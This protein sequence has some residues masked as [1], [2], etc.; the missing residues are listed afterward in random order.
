MHAAPLHNQPAAAHESES[1]PVGKLP[2]LTKVGL[3]MVETPPE[4]VA[5]TIEEVAIPKRSKRKI[6][7]EAVSVA[8]AEPLLQVETR[9]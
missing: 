9:E 6:N 2:D 4:K 7:K 3:I 1:S 8:P 5:A